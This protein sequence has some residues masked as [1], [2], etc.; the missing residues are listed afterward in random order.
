MAQDEGFTDV[1]NG[2]DLNLGPSEEPS[3]N[4]A[5]TPSSKQVYRR[6]NNS[7]QYNPMASFTSPADSTQSEQTTCKLTKLK[8]I[9]EGF[10]L[11][12]TYE[13]TCAL[14]LQA[15]TSA[16]PLRSPPNSS[17]YDRGRSASASHPSSSSSKRRT[18]H[19]NLRHTSSSTALQQQHA[20]RSSRRQIHLSDHMAAAIELS[21]SP[22]VPPAPAAGMYWSRAISFGRGPSRPLRA[23]TSNLI[24]EHLYV[25]GGCDIKACFNTLYILDMCK[26]RC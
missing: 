14:F 8:G 18:S 16:S 11:L 20:A 12:I 19:N 6:N 15:T 1:S 21:T 24:G 17:G 4:V 3:L 23:H 5:P 2:D 26:I 25:F 13:L 10:Y 9:G 7:N 22:N